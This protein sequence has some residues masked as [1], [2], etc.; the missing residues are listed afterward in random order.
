MNA[1]SRSV[2]RADAIEWMDANV[3]P[4]D[5]S[6]ITSLPDVSELAGHDLAAWR[7]FFLAAAR[8]VIR[9]TPPEGVAIFYQ[10]DIRMGGAHIDKGYLVLRAAE[11]EEA[12]AIWHKIVCRKPPGFI[13]HG[14]ASYS[15][16]IAVTRGVVPPMRAPG[17]EVLPDAG[18]MP[19][20]RAMGA[21]ACR[22]ACRYLL[23]NTKTRVVVDP[24]CGRGTVL[25][26][27]NE[28]GLDAIGIDISEGRCRKARAIS[29][30]ELAS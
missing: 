1:P 3:A 21:T 12:P 13:A 24:F 15:H 23:D 22:V 28:L 18:P 20:S 16:M 4:P 10:S 9:W 25:A 7:A 14:R 6:V 8:R 11:E 5:A 27:A 17:P 19:W 2:V 30:A 29:P 26:I